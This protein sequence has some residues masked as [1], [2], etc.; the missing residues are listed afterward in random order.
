MQSI[1]ETLE[2][3][4]LLSTTY[5]VSVGGSDSGAG[6]QAAPLATIQAAANKVV[7]G[8]TVI[9]EAGTYAGF[10]LSYDNPQA[11]TASA[12]ITFEADP[13]AA[14]GSVIIGSRNNKTQTAID[15]EPGSD[16]VTIKGFTITN[17]GDTETK[18]GI[19][20]TGNYDQII[21]NTVTGAAGI[22]G[23]FTDN[24]NYAVVDNNTITGT[25][26]TDEEGHGIY[27]SGT[28]TG[29]DVEYNTIDA[30]GYH[31]IHLN[32]DA[33][34]GGIGEVID[35]TVSNNLIYN[36]PGNGIN[37]DGL[38]DSVI[39]NNLIYGY[40]KYG[41][42]IYSE[43]AGV[44]STGNVI[45]NNTIDGPNIAEFQNGAT[46]VLFNNILVGSQIQTDGTATLTQSNNINVASLQAPL[47]ASIVDGNFDLLAGSPAIGA[48]VA[49][50]D[51]YSA[52][53]TDLLGDARP[54]GRFD[55]GAY[56]YGGTPP[57]VT[58]PVVKNLAE[59]QI[60]S[61]HLNQTVVPW[62]DGDLIGDGVVDSHDLQI[63]SA[64]WH[65]TIDLP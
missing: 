8:D 21:D 43:D 10:I 52:P 48:G 54:G 58:V 29:V 17:V 62:T 36:N 38:V 65:Q 32:G 46:A 24:A 34:E 59:F 41:I 30:N 1:F 22:G 37:A 20:A 49:S 6:T 3:R 18:A 27:I 53:T 61:A 45:V 56:E 26:G 55:A 42:S 31:G 23:I 15:L 39:E 4:R 28:C 2:N 44:P 63:L 33:S 35:A 9:V 19:K 57:V 60:I 47:L 5:Y 12:P 13:N 7:A 64:D 14:A 11:G 25:Q 51:G 40:T 50:F 16:Y